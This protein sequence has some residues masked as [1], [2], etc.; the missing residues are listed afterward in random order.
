MLKNPKNVQSLYNRVNKINNKCPICGRSFLNL[1][2]HHIDRDR[3]NN[4][5][6]NI[7]LVCLKCHKLIHHPQRL[8]TRKVKIDPEIR[9]KLKFY[10]DIM[11]IKKV[12]I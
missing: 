1:E 8:F 7:L 5:I 11:V 3:S 10:S 12:N 9:K 4:H 2:L 6:N